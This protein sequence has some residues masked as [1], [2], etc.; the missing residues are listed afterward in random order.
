MLVDLSLKVS[1]LC[2]LNLCICED[3]VLTFEFF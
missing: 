1:D 3:T 2:K